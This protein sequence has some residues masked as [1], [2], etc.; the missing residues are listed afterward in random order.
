MSK[1]RARLRLYKDILDARSQRMQRGKSEDT[2][3]G[4]EALGELDADPAEALLPAEA[5]PQTRP[6]SAAPAQVPQ[7]AHPPDGHADKHDKA[8]RKG[9]V[10]SWLKSKPGDDKSHAP[11]PGN[12][13]PAPGSNATGAAARDH[14]DDG[15][16]MPEFKPL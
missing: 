1:R 10:L 7:P 11:A 5:E 6:V 15:N 13:T 2:L 12:N 8:K 16:D 9:G 14:R 3:V 4:E